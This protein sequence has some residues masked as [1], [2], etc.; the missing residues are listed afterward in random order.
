MLCSGSRAIKVSRIIRGGDVDTLCVHFPR[1]IAA[2][3]FARY[4]L[5]SL[6]H[7]V[8]SNVGLSQNIGGIE[9]AESGERVGHGSPLTGPCPHISFHQRM[10]E[11]VATGSEIFPRRVFGLIVTDSAFA[12]AKDHCGGAHSG[13]VN[14]VMAGA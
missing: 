10:Q 1:A 14:R 6:C 11:H 4:R 9:P 5:E 8:V 7:L 13:H 12:R 3:F 2:E